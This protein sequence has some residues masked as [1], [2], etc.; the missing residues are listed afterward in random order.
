MQLHVVLMFI[1]LPPVVGEDGGGR[2]K[3]EWSITG[4]HLNKNIY[5]FLASL[6]VALTS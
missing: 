3:R 2:N 5:A 6:F 4:Q 1:E